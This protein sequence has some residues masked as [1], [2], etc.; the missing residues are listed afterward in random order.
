MGHNTR[1][2]PCRSVLLRNVFISPVPQNRTT[3]GGRFAMAD[4]R[5]V[6]EETPAAVGVLVRCG[7]SD[8]FLHGFPARR[9]DD[10]GMA[11]GHRVRERRH[12]LRVVPA[13]PLLW[14]G[15]P[16]VCAPPF[17]PKN[18]LS[19]LRC[20]RNCGNS[21]SLFRKS[22]E[23]GIFVRG[24]TALPVANIVGD[25]DHSALGRCL[26]CRPRAGFA[27]HGK[28]IPALFDLAA[29][30]I[31]CGNVLRRTA[32]ETEHRRILSEWFLS[33][34]GHVLALSGAF[35]ALLAPLR[36]GHT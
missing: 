9:M 35:R 33:T 5:E 21:S 22:L 12:F 20:H 15:I 31:A 36:F 19:A 34:A 25:I 26:V 1:C 8:V 29:G 13:R 11:L 10:V 27:H 17:V 4:F 6:F 14:N 24:D 30:G 3:P 32:T 18:F 28:G 16:A 23:R 2:P 7:N